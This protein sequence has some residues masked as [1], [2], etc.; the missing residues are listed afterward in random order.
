MATIGHTQTST[1]IHPSAAHLH[2][3]QL[4]LCVYRQ[5]WSRAKWLH[6]RLVGSYSTGVPASYHDSSY[7]IETE[8]RNTEISAMVIVFWNICNIRTVPVHEHHKTALQSSNQENRYL[9]PHQHLISAASSQS[10]KGASFNT[11][12]VWT[13]GVK[14]NMDNPGTN[15]VHFKG[16]NFE[17]TLDMDLLENVDNFEIRD[18]DVFI[19]T[20]PKSGTIWAQQILSLIYFEGHRNRMENLETAFRVPFFEYSRRLMDIENRPSPRLF[21]SHLPYYL[22]PKGLKNKKAK[23]IYVYR[24]P[25]DVLVSYFYFSN[26][27][28]THEPTDTI[29]HFMEKFLVGEVVGSLWFD[30]IRGWYE[31]KHD[32][33]IL[34]MM[35]EDMKKDFR[36]SVLEISKFLSKNLSEQDVD[37]MVNQATFENMK[38]LPQANYTNTIE[39]YAGM[40]FQEGQFMR[41]GTIGDWKHHLTVKQNERFD[42]IF[43]TKMKD[44]PLKSIWDID[45]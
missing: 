7:H 38:S 15:V 33:N 6:N 10:K 23:V 29:G 25:K 24:N 31:H 9:T 30:H 17:S 4:L 34:F 26:W 40:R 3:P 5:N 36:S 44:F 43:Q 21:T 16:F 42:K 13:D 39:R 28:E 22:A 12:R 18:D 1:H 45:E 11:Q 8:I 41:K 27:L 35:Y 20:Y 2:V 37:A 14:Q 32:F 19:I